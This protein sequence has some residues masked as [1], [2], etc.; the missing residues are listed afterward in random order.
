MTKTIKELQALEFAIFQTLTLDDFYEVEFLCKLHGELITCK[1]LLY[2][3]N[4]YRPIIPPDYK[5]RF[6]PTTFEP[7]DFEK[8][9]ELLQL[10]EI[11]DIRASLVD[12]QAN[13]IAY[14]LNRFLYVDFISHFDEKQL[15]KLPNML[16][17]VVFLGSNLNIPF[18]FVDKDEPI[19]VLYATVT[20]K[21]K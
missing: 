21:D 10:T 3:N 1:S 14:F 20:L 5:S 17:N 19:T 6:N 15:S 7:I 11:R 13:D 9:L 12:W 2:A 16:N 18:L 8:L 4:P